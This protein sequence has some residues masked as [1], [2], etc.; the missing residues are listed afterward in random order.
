M[1]MKALF[2]L[3]LEKHEDGLV[4]ALIRVNPAAEIYG[5]HFPAF[6]LTPG[7]CQV[8]MIRTSLE[9][10]LGR[11]LRLSVARSIKFTR[12]HEPGLTSLLRSRVSYREE[13]GRIH[14]DGSVFMD[15]TIF[16]K[17]KGSF[18]ERQEGI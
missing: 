11:P 5:G 10:A 14:A 3:T 15:E 1:S 9:E 16:L 4:E 8:H 17:F 7:V 18:V 12:M 6:P 2:S 13:E